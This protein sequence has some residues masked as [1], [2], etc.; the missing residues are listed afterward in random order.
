MRIAAMVVMAGLAGMSARAGQIGETVTVFLSNTAIVP[1]EV[2]FV[3]Q[4]LAARMFV[5]AGVRIV[6]RLG[7][8]ADLRSGRDRAIVVRLTKDTPANYLPGVPAYALPY[9]GDQITVLYDRVEQT[10]V[11]YAVPILLAHVLVHEIT[12][13]LQGINRHSE[14]GVMKAHW[15]GGDYM[16]MGKKLLPFTEADVELIHRGLAVR[17]EAGAL[18]AATH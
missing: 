1:S 4:N 5:S 11:P 6:W 8:P 13:I 16:A 12:H 2:M 14:S 10:V 18:V 7:G 17:A 15:D 9:Q 3:S